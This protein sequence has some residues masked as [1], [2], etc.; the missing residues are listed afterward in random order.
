MAFPKITLLELNEFNL[1]LLERGTRELRLPSVERLLDLTRFQTTTQDSYQDRSLEPWVQWVSIHT[2][3]PSTEHGVRHIGDLPSQDHVQLWEALS[4]AGVSTGIWGVLNGARR[5]A[6][7]CRFFVPDP[8]T[9]SERASPA[10]LD[11]LIALPRFM[12]KNRL[13][14]AQPRALFD[15]ARLGRAFARPR[16]LVALARQA[17]RA[18]PEVPRG[19]RRAYTWFTP[20]EFLSAQRFARFKHEADPQ[21]CLLFINMLAHAQHYYWRDVGGRLGPELSYVLRFVDRVA[22]LVLDGLRPGEE[23]IVASG[24]EQFQLPSTHDHHVYR[25]R[26]H[27]R[28]LG[29]I[30]ERPVEV[31][32]H[33]TNDAYLGFADASATERAVQA[34]EGAEV[35]GE[36]LFDVHRSAHR[37]N[38]LF[39][40]VR[41][42]KSLPQDAT[43]TLAGQSYA[44]WEHFDSLGLHTGRHGTRGDVLT[45]LPPPG[46]SIPNHELFHWITGQYGVRGMSAPSRSS[47][48]DSPGT[49][50]TALTDAL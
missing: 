43:F 26:D 46:P 9:F 28:F 50:G 48:V 41:F 33:M 14:L 45:T 23:L 30:G 34:L 49:G 2:G 21:F 42:G 1:D 31:D 25:P 18:L 24:F 8:W 5:Q 20:F 16:D 36:P 10:P 3:V 11:D 35:C 6:E 27:G 39:Y 15:A 29:L 38:C 22:E 37:P 47:V 32:A 17:R 7:T 12:A 4:E 13:N 40:Q 19:A 44:F